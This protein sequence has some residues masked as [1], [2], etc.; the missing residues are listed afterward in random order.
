MIVKQ[1]KYKGYIWRIVQTNSGCLGSPVDYQMI[2]DGVFSS[3]YF[4]SL[5]A[6]SVK[7]EIAQA[8]HFINE[9]IRGRI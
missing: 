8:K 5:E 6:W 2:V 4:R 9:R 1:G 3:D 7:R